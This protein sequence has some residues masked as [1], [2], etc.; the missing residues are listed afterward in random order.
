MLEKLAGKRRDP[1]RTLEPSAT[2][3]LAKSATCCTIGEKATAYMTGGAVREKTPYRS[4]GAHHGLSSSHKHHNHYAEPQYSYVDRD[5]A[6][7]LRHKSNH[8]DLRP[9]RSTRPLRTGKSES[10]GE[11]RGSSNLMKLCPVEIPVGTL[12]EEPNIVGDESTPTNN[13][14]GGAEVVDPQIAEREAKRK[15]IQSLIMKYSALDEAYNRATNNNAVQTAPMVVSPTV[16]IA[17]KYQQILPTAVALTVSTMWPHML[18]ITAAAAAATDA[19]LLSVCNPPCAWS[20]LI[21]GRQMNV[22]N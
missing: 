9:R 6:Y 5:S 12:Y 11:R 10:S 16:A 15:E 13:A 19:V 7:H 1:E 2:R 18:F 4:G 8:S 3:I 14:A 22:T 17:Q 21:G 20:T